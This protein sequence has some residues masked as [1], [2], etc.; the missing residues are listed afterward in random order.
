MAPMARDE[1]IKEL[2]EILLNKRSPFAK[3][4]QMRLD[5]LSDSTDT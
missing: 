2:R 3:L 4:A 5:A 1:E